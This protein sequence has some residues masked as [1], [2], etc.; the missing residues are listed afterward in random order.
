MDFGISVDNRIELK[1]CEKRD[2][3]QDLAWELKRIWNM[4]VTVISVV[5]GALGKIPK[6]LVKRLEDL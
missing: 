1:E 6:G 3:Y 5:V 4:K 2:K